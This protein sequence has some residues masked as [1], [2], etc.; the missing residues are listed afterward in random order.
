MRIFIPACHEAICRQSGRGPGRR[1][2]ARPADRLPQHREQTAYSGCRRRTAHRRAFDRPRARAFARHAGIG[3]EA[4]TGGVESPRAGRTLWHASRHR[5]CRPARCLGHRIDRNCRRGYIG[6]IGDIGSTSNAAGA[7][8]RSALRS[9]APRLA[10]HGPEPPTLFR[11]T[12]QQRTRQHAWT[13][14]GYPPGHRH[15]HC[16]QGRLPAWRVQAL[17]SGCGIGSGVQIALARRRPRLGRGRVR[18][19]ESLRISSPSSTAGRLRPRALLPGP[20]SSHSAI[21]ASLPIESIPS[22][23]APERQVVGDLQQPACDER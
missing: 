19:L 18:C 7:T 13:V 8:A 10:R 9:H 4:I 11:G 22:H 16:A 21:R 5:A 14:V 23:G 20:N 1:C 2:H 12:V 3:A 6:Y 17:D 15:R